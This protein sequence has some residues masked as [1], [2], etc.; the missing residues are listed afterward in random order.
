MG[1]DVIHK[2]KHDITEWKYFSLQFDES[3]DFIDIAQ[4]CIYIRMSFNDMTT[5]EDLLTIIPLKG[6]TRREDI[7][8]AFIKFV[9]KLPLPL[10]KLVCVITDSAPAMV[11]WLNGFVA[12]CRKNDDFPDFVSFHCYTSARVVCKNAKYERGDGYCF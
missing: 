5:K 11:V 1:I 2:L 10:N 3:T 7:Y 8:C 12:L 4:L 9:E 6:N